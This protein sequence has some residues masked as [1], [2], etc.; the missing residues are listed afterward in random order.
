MKEQ[1][2]WKSHLIELYENT[3]NL[4]D[5]FISTLCKNVSLWLNFKLSK[6]QV[7]N[8]TLSIINLFNLKSM[9]WR[10]NRG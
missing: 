3:I 5:I 9:F 4:N 10:K 7:V 1:K 6:I 2:N 8:A